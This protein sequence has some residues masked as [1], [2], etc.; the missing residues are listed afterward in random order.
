MER[1][2]EIKRQKPRDVICGGY[3]NSQKHAQ[4]GYRLAPSGL[5]LLQQLQEFIAREL[6]LLEDVL[7]V[8]WR[9]IAG[10]HRDGRSSRRVA[11]VDQI[12]MAAFDA[13]GHETRPLQGGKHLPRADLRQPA[14]TRASFTGTTS[15]TVLSGSAS[16]AGMGLP[17]S[18]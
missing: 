16:D 9:Q 5:R 14:H 17:S 7:H 15:L 10:V 18:R 4:S 12:V 11:L 3:T 1:A 8:P 2:G 13:P 6:G